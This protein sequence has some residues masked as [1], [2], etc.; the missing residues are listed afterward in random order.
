[1]YLMIPGLFLNL[2]QLSMSEQKAN[3]TCNVT[4]QFSY[5]LEKQVFVR[6]QRPIFPGS[7]Q[8]RPASFLPL[9]LPS[10]TSNLL[11][12]VWFCP[13]LQRPGWYKKLVGISQHTMM[14]GP[15]EL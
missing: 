9:Y 6:L 11:F 14:G 13:R 10:W 4:W 15:E 12:Q 3:E 1:M 5:T 7:P 2:E 8:C